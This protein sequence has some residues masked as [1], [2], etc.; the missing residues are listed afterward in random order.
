V[1]F[2]T[3]LL[4]STGALMIDTRLFVLNSELNGIRL[5]DAGTPKAITW[6]AL[7]N[8]TPTPTEGVAGTLYARGKATGTAEYLSAG[9]E[10][11]VANASQGVGELRWLW[12]TSAGTLKRQ[13]GGYFTP[14]TDG[15]YISSPR[16][17]AGSRRRR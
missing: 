2:Y 8:I 17:A 5:V 6:Q 15:S 16:R 13:A 10:L 7:A 4:V 9:V 3:S 14:P 11:R 12:Q 1:T